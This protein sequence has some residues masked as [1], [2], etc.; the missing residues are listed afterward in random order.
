MKTVYSIP[1]RQPTSFAAAAAGGGDGDGGNETKRNERN[2]TK[3]PAAA[4]R[5]ASM[6]MAGAGRRGGKGVGLEIKRE[7]LRVI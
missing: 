7:N 1:I 3:G 5:V 2:E 4:R 6:D